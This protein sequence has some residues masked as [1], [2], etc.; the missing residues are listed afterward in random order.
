MFPHVHVQIV[1][2]F[3]DIAA[4]GTH[5]VLVVRMCEHVLGEVGLV[6]APEV[7]LATLVRL[8]TFF[9]ERESREERKQKRWSD[10]NHTRNTEVM[11]FLKAK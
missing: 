10:R 7:T 4:L 8:L 2:P 6:P 5:E 3:C 11:P 9:K 1:L